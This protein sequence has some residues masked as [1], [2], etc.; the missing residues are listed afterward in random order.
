[1]GTSIERSAFEVEQRVFSVR[2]GTVQVERLPLFRR[3]ARPVLAQR[4]ENVVQRPVQTKLG[5]TALF[6]ARFHTV[7]FIVYRILAAIDIS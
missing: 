7:R 1:M 2:A 6:L 5:Q 3:L 4:A